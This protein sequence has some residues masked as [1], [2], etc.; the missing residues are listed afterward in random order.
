MEP[1]LFSFNS[2]IG[3]CPNC[4]GLG[5]TFEPD[6]EKMIPHL[7]LSILDGGIEYYKNTAGTTNIE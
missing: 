5:V 1:R 4:K 3:A 2:P 6:E 7:E